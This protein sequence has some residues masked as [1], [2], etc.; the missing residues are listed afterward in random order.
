MHLATPDVSMAT[1]PISWHNE[2]F[3][4]RIWQS[5]CLWLLFVTNIPKY[6]LTSLVS[7]S[8]YSKALDID[9]LLFSSNLNLMHPVFNLTE[10]QTHDFWIM[11]KNIFCPDALAIS[12]TSPGMMSS[13]F[14]GV[15]NI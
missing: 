7:C 6:M 10:V 11:K 8:Y 5:L 3:M 12:G 1:F 2:Y 4:G 15:A 9:F 14:Q 13:P